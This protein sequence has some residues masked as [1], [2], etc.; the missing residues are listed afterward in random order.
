MKEALKAINQF[1]AD[2]TEEEGGGDPPTPPRPEPIY[3]NIDSTRLYAGVPRRVQV[4]INLDLVKEGEIVLFESDR[5]EMKIEP[6]SSVTQ[7]KKKRTHQRIDVVISCD[8]KGVKGTI[9]ALSLNKDGKEIRAELRILGV[10]DPPLFVP[11]KDISFT[12]SR[13]SG[14]S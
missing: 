3:F 8:V 13:Y 7:E 4:Y 12:A 6:D 2:E 5:V 14:V 10:D 1:N 9:T 11:P